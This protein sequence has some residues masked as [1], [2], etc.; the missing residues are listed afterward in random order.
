MAA[1]SL[2]LDYVYD[3]EAS[4]PERIYLTQPIGG[5]KVIDYTWGQVVDEAR[6]MVSSLAGIKPA[7]STSF[8]VYTMSPCSILPH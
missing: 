5:G 8:C 1:P 3:R 7:G 4:H 6:R 2:L